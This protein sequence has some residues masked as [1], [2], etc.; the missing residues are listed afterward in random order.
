[1]ESSSDKKVFLN[2]L[3]FQYRETKGHYHPLIQEMC[4]SDRESVFKYV[5]SLNM[6]FVI[7][8]KY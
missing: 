2:Y 4:M 8:L 7:S 5:T 3:I 1:M 6:S